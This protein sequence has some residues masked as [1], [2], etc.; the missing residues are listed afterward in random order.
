MCVDL[1][2]HLVEYIARNVRIRIRA[3]AAA[4]WVI[5]TDQGWRA[6]HKKAC[7]ARRPSYHLYYCTIPPLSSTPHCP[8]TARA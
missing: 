4:G 3:R 6:E 7:V 5:L 1:S 8:V 2:R